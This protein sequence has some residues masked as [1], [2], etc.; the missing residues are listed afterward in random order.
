MN[1]GYETRKSG[2]LFSAVILPVGGVSYA[3]VFL[4]W[5]YVRR[6]ARKVAVFPVMSGALVKYV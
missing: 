6:I 4:S 3:L 5:R 2:V 1:I